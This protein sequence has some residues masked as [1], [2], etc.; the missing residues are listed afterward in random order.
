MSRLI[1]ELKKELAK[2]DLSPQEIQI[3]RVLEAG[4]GIAAVAGVPQVMMSETVVFET[5]SGPVL[6]SV[7]NLEEDRVGV[8]ILGRE[9]EISEGTLVKATGKILSVPVGE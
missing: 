5:G 7:L 9:T 1:E 6:G 4:D 2:A 3:G 8:M